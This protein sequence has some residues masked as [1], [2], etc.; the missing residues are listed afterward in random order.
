VPQRGLPDGIAWRR[1]RR[2]FLRAASAGLAAA[3]FPARAFAGGER[4][5]RFGLTPVLLNTDLDLLTL[6]RRYL[7]SAT[8]HS[9][10]LVTRRTYQEITA[11]LVS[12]QLEAAWICGY[13]FVKYR[14]QLSLVAVPEWNGRPLY[15]S[16]LIVGAEREAESMRDL[17]GDIH[18]FSDPDS[19]S[20]YLVTRTLM[21]DL[22]LDPETFFRKT[23]FTYGHRNVVRAV[24]SGLAQSGSVDGYVWEVLRETEPEL[25]TRTRVLRKSELLGFPPVATSRAMASSPAIAALKQALLKMRDTA[26]GRRVLHELRLT[27][28]VEVDASVY[29]GI[30]AKVV[31]L[32]GVL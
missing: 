4:P 11:L 23:L 29:D 32:R 9:I 25:V 5:I 24:A 6:L 13:P 22:G 1:S 21:F 27:G 2:M 28:F 15:R 3:V 12:G 26:D 17:R 20:G 14:E 19:N 31:K 8:G 30:A 16:Y 7:E 10:E 18:A